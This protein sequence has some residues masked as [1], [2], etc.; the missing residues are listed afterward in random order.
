MRL[1]ATDLDGTLLNSNHNI[2]Q[3]NILAILEAQR[4]G[5]EV[6]IST[7]RTFNSAKSILNT[8][9]IDTPF[10]ISSNGSQIHTSQGNELQSYPLKKSV[11][12]KLLPYLDLNNFYYVISTDNYIIEPSNGRERLIADFYKAKETDDSL[13]EEDLYNLLDLF[14]ISDTSA[15]LRQADS[16]YDMM[17]D[18][19]YNI[20]I[21]SFSQ[22]KLLRGR[23]ALKDIKGI[24]IVS[25]HDNNFEIV[26][27]L[28]S[29]GNAVEYVAN[30]LDISLDDVMAIGDNFN[31]LSMFKKVKYSVAMGNAK[32]D[33]KKECKFVTLKNDEHGVAHAIYEHIK[34]A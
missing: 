26:S 4:K 25:S 3:E 31:D 14:Y 7:G 33:I 19:C 28:S 9:G 30:S 1:I 5:I 21:V 11:L 24:S 8:A 34:L 20:A 32:D 12:E 6:I 16:I 17:N 15:E 23:K 29:K 27:D 22:N 10:I 18:H 2:S 13:K